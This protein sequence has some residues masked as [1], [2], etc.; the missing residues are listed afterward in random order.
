MQELGED[1]LLLLLLPSSS[2]SPWP[3]PRPRCALDDTGDA[4]SGWSGGLRLGG[5]TRFRV[6]R[7]TVGAAM[8]VKG[9]NAAIDGVEALEVT[10]TIHTVAQWGVV[11]R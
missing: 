8:G 7:R 3:P 11:Q 1:E 6:G 2:G 5:S 10:G 9:V 4:Q